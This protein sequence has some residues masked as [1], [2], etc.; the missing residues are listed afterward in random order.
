MSI[1]FKKP[2]GGFLPY[3]GPFCD[4]RHVEELL[5]KA[6]RELPPGNTAHEF[7]QLCFE[8]CT[9]CGEKLEVDEK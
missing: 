7:E 9:V 4:C 8:Y 1:K 5:L 3:Y 6:V 2:G